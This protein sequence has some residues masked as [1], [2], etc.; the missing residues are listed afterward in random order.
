VGLGL[1]LEADDRR[2]ALRAFRA[3]RSALARAGV[4]PAAD[5][6]SASALERL[7]DAKLDGSP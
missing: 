5:G 3:A 6:W 4:D 1:A 7:L 2:A